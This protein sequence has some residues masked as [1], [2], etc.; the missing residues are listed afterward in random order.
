MRDSDQRNVIVA[1]RVA[2]MLGFLAILL[3]LILVFNFGF[4]ITSPIIFSLSFFFFMITWLNKRGF[5][6]LGRTLLCVVPTAITLA[7]ALLSKQN[8]PNH[9]DILYYDAR[10][11]L[12]LLAIVPCLIF[13]TRERI[14]LYGCLGF[15]FLTLILFDP[16]HEYFHLGYFQKGFTG[17][18][19]YYINYVAAITFFGIAAG[20][21]N[22]KRVIEKKE[23]KNKKFEA[24]LIEKNG[25][26]SEALRNLEKQK[27]EIIA[28]SDELM[29]SQEQLVAA[30][31]LI[32]KQKTELQQQV[33]QAN[34]NLEEANEELI[35][36]NNELRQFS[37]TISHNLR[38]PIARLLGLAQVAKLDENFDDN[39]EALK[40][41]SHIKTSALEL[42]NVIR[43]LNQIVDIRNGINQ[44]RQE[45]AFDKEWKEIRALLHITDAMADENF[46]VDFQTPILYSVRPMVNSILY[47]LVSNAIKYQSPERKL[48]IQL[49]SF[50]TGDYTVLQ[51]TDNGLGINLKQFQHDLFKLYKRFHT[52]QEGKGLGLYLI[53]S[54]A[55]SLN[56]YVE[57]ESEP[58]QG[59]TFRV[60]IKGPSEEEL[61]QLGA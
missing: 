29:A 9:T 57:C 48:Q 45:I 23:R 56:G 43:D 5:I 34:N 21:I 22:L 17:R 20:S 11:F 18:S 12:V 31:R 42:D 4:T 39:S 14:L 54:Q 51:V 61:A 30:N 16:I 41:I 19:Y 25:Q 27:E 35:K 13:N 38:G 26:L 3:F 1:N 37:Y 15:T 36:H 40:L 60:Y 8:E 52:H 47:N 58:D 59:T 6:N 10:F 2:N 28:Q 32:E 44:L 55:E 46:I 7:A 24:D 33:N 50:Q 49:T 53:K